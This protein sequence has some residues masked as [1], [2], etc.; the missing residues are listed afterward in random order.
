MAKRSR[1][2]KLWT[3]VLGSLALLMLALSGEQVYG[4]PLLSL[5]VAMTGRKAVYADLAGGGVAELGRRP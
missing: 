2:A 5:V 1:I 3:V 4:R